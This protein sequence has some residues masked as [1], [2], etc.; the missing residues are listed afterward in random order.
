MQHVTKQEILG[1]N[2]QE[3]EWSHG[4]VKPEWFRVAV[5]SVA[6]AF[7]VVLLIWGL[8]LDLGV[9]PTL[10][11]YYGHRTR[12]AFVGMLF[13]IGLALYGY[14]G[15]DRKDHRSTNLAGVLAV[16][17]AVFPAHGSNL[18]GIL[19]HG[20]AAV[21]FFTLALIAL[22]LFTKKQ[23]PVTPRKIIRNRF[24]RGCGVTILGCLVLIGVIVFTGLRARLADLNPVL[25][26]ESVMVWAFGLAWLIKAEVHPLLAAD[27]REPEFVA[28]YR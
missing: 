10:S 27:A 8:F 15:Y 12:D 2:R 6:L 5:G 16:L 3:G 25:W 13:I 7:P 4:I 1:A 19:H 17:V 9:L 21:F 26:L 11:D 14:R 22:R 20:S 18:D 28:T 23:A 24:Y